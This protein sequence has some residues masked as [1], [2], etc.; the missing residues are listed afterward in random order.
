M[1]TAETSIFVDSQKDKQR[2]RGKVCK[3]VI[4]MRES[5]INIRKGRGNNYYIEKW[6]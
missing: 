2:I 1:E 3:E 4:W 5:D 6:K